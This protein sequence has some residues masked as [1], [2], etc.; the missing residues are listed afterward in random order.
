MEDRVMKRWIVLTVFAVASFGAMAAPAQAATSVGVSIQVGDA[1]R[2]ASIDFRS[3][4][5][6]VVVP[7][8]KVYYVREY[9]SDLYRYGKYWYFVEGG[10]WYRA[11]SWRG[12]F[13]HVHG[14]SV[15]RSVRTVPVNYRR[16]W[17]GPPPHAVARG[18]DKGPDHPGQGHGNKKHKH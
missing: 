13:V 14:N 16:N 17:N 5:E 10:Y 18:Y 12:P 2:G 8:T 11:R 7:A 9:D 6:V 15:P 3:E 4:P 1:Y